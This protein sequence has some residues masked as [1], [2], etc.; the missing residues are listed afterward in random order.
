MIFWAGFP[1]QGKNGETNNL[2][3]S[4]LALIVTGICLNYLSGFLTL[5]AREFL[6]FSIYFEREEQGISLHCC[7][8]S[9]Q[10]SQLRKIKISIGVGVGEHQTL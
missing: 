10:F 5:T 6:T 1:E 4:R 2:Q 9:L 8:W 3:F 7:S